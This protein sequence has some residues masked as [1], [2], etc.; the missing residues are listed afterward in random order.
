[1]QVSPQR[2]KS[3]SRY[4]PWTILAAFNFGINMGKA[5]SGLYPGLMVNKA[6]DKKKK[7]AMCQHI[8][9]LSSSSVTSITSWHPGKKVSLVS[10]KHF[11]S[12]QNAWNPNKLLTNCEPGASG[13]QISTRS[14]SSLQETLSQP[15]TVWPALCQTHQV[16]CSEHCHRSA[17][18]CLAQIP[19]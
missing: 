15:L 7:S 8:L 17:P 1:M 4:G 19:L 3:S 9:L 14:F 2:Q 13:M 11:L 5:I 16:H 10:L 6:E 12:T 18:C